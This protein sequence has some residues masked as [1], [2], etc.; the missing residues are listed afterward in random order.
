MINLGAMRQYLKAHGG[1]AMLTTR[2]YLA[3]VEDKETP[4][5]EYRLLLLMGEMDYTTA[6]YATEEEFR[7]DEAAACKKVLDRIVWE[8]HR[9]TGRTFDVEEALRSGEA[10]MKQT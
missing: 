7:Q 5:L 1:Q 4:V 9:D 6:C 10:Y 3:K 2:R 8:S